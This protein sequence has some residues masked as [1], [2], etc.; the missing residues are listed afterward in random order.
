MRRFLVA[1][2]A[3]TALAL[4]ALPA[5]AQTGGGELLQGLA[6]CLDYAGQSALPSLAQAQA[7]TPGGYGPYGW[8]PLTQPFGAGPIGPATAYS[9]PGLAPVYGPLGPGLTAMNI[10][11]TAIPPGGFGFQNQ[12]VN[13]Y[14]NAQTL[15]GLAGLQQGELGTLQ[16]RYGLAAG[17]QTAGATWATGLSARAGA[18]LAVAMALC[19]GQSASPP[20]PAGLVQPMAPS[21]GPGMMPAGAPM[22]PGMMP[23]GTQM[24]PGVMPLGALPTVPVMTPPASG[25][26][27]N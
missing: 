27:S 13:N 12:N 25:G 1:L 3:S 20:A 16:G 17:Y 9:P 21:M 26:T 19:L 23:S 10:A 22:A 8:A 4:P 14:L 11:A 5:S 7:F 2:L 24:A 18:T 6:N 15:I